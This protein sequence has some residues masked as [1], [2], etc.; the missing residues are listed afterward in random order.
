MRILYDH[1]MFGL[2]QFGGIT[3]LFI[4]MMRRLSRRPD[5][6]IDWHRGCHADGYDVSTYRPRLHR[7]WAYNKVPFSGKVW[8]NA[9]TFNRFSFRWFTRITPRQY[10]IYHPTY[11]DRSL[12][13]CVR[14]RKLALTVPDLIPEKYFMAQPRFE[15]LL[16]DRRELIAR[17][18]LLL[19]ISEST[20][21]DLLE[22]HRVDPAKVRLTYLAS[23]MKDVEPLDFRFSIDDFRLKAPQ[24]QAESFG[25][26]IKNRKS[27]IENAL[28]YFLYVGTRSKY[29]NFQVLLEAFARSEWLKRHARLVCF[30]GSGPYLPAELDFMTQHGLRGNFHYLS[31]DDALLKALYQ[32]AQALVYT[33]RY[34]GFGLPPLEAMECGCP[35]ACCPTSSL[36]EVVGD[37]AALFDPDAPDELAAV[38]R[39]LAEDQSQREALIARGRIQA[40]RFSWDRTAEQTLAAYRSLVA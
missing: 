29:K 13:K 14:V 3:R 30:G 36:P 32:N 9:E 33:S 8:K 5:C 12:L 2:Q 24:R 28:P 26:Q 25:F 37:A 31:G 4:E 7:Y 19:V 6:R 11:Y 15:R 38:L 39:T 27:T 35:V 20:R 17:A 18:D 22:I 34:E 16:D 23:I 40:A 10:D 21:R 1:Q